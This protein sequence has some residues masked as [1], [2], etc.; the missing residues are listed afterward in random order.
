M[1]VYIRKFEESDIPYKI[2]WIND[3][4]N[5]K[6]LHY[7]LPLQYDKTLEWFKNIQNREDRADYTIVYKNNP[8]GLIGLLNIDKKNKK[9]E[10]YIC[11]GEE[12]YKGKGIAFF[13]T[14]LLLDIA[15]KKLGLNKVY[16]FTEKDN[17]RAQKFF[18]KVGFKKEG[19]L[20]HDLIHNGRK[21]D[22]Y[23]YGICLDDYIKDNGNGDNQNEYNSFK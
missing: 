3:E 6:Y 20:K 8:V 2:K 21:I 12:K 9:A 13:A 11:L 19:L 7:E 22:R 18:E 15:F 5:N 16:L 4:K 17:I 14:K 10:Y 1:D 23:V